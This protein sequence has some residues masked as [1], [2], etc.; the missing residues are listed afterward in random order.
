MLNYLLT[1]VQGDDRQAVRVG[2]QLVHQA[3]IY[4]GG[5]RDDLQDFIQICVKQQRVLQ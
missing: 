5:T 2:V 1:Q 4:T 3:Q